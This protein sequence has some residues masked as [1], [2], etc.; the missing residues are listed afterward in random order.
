MESVNFDRAAGFYDATRGFP[1]GVAEQVGVFIAEKTELPQDAKALEIGI[2]TGRVSLPLAGHVGLVA[3]ADISSEMMKVLLVKRNDEAVYPTQAD[4]TQLPYADKCFDAVLI[5]H[6][7]HLVPD[8]IAILRDVQ[9]VLKADGILIHGFNT[10]DSDDNPMAVA[11]NANRPQRKLGH[12]YDSTKNALD[13]SGWALEETH[14]F[15]YSYTETPQDFLHPFESR[16]WSSTW[17]VSDDELAKAVNA[18]KQAIDEHY[19]GD[20]QAQIK[21]EAGF[22][23][24]IMRPSQ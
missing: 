8:P 18:V 23:I 13:E 21:R 1:E 24:D 16:A 7:L 14:I 2:G 4:G 6:V 20:Y 10:R 15:S 9:R 11:W 17:D 3:G 19:D 12:N 5:V 22:N